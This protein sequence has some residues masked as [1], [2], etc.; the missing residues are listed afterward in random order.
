MKRMHERTSADAA[1][2]LKHC[3][4]ELEFSELDPDL[5][6][7]HSCVGFWDLLPR[8]DPSQMIPRAEE[9]GHPSMAIH[10]PSSRPCSTSSSSGSF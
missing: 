9:T 6:L 10:T 3:V 5:D 1:G 7:L 2:N 4:L 8:V